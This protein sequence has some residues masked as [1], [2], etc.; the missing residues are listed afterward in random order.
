MMVHRPN[1]AMEAAIVY[2]MKTPQV[3]IDMGMAKRAAAMGRVLMKKATRRNQSKINQRRYRAQQKCTTDLL[4]QT[5]IQLRTDVA[6]MEGR[7]EM[8]K[9][10]I[11]P[12]LRT[13]E[14]ECNVANEYFRMFVYGYNLDPACA[15][16][17]TQFDF[18]NSTM[19]PDLVIMGNIGLDKLLQQWMLYVNTFEAFHMELHQ[20]HVVSFSPNVVVHAQTTLHL[21]ISRKSI[22]LLFPHLL[23]NEPLTQKLIGRVLHLY[24]QQHFIFDHHG[25]VQELGT[26]ANT[27]LALVNL[28]G[29]LDDV[30]AVIGDFHLGENAEIVVVSTDDRLASYPKHSLI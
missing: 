2:A 29:N 25:I 7:L 30:L 27:T 16:H 20:A 24:S 12:P 21:R 26:F 18:L 22:Q 3:V 17:T 23:N 1:F 6:R 9:L 10:A 8:M 11:P 15:Q 4:N 28:L 13:F 19:S 5:V 14:P